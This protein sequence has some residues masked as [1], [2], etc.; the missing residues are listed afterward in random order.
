MTSRISLALHVACA[1]TT[2]LMATA[3]FAEGLRSTFA[4][5]GSHATLAGQKGL[6]ADG[7]GNAAGAAR[8]GFTTA[9]GGQGQ[10]SAQFNRTS[11]GAAAASGQAT[12]SGS[13]GS[14][15]RSGSFT[16]D[17]DGSASGERSTTVTNANTGVTYDGS[18]TYTKGAGVSRTGG[19]KDASGNSVSCVSR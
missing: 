10:R 5:H 13:N 9:S 12:A 16:R 4:A 3:A 2:S 14:A 17:A 6:V 1:L 11:D 7:Q 19:C 18:T 15:E 8:S